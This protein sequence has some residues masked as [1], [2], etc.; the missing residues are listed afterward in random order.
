MNRH[1]VL[2]VHFIIYRFAL[3]LSCVERPARA[4][5]CVYVAFNRIYDT[6]YTFQQT[7]HQPLKLLHG[8]FLFFLLL[9]FI[10]VFL[11]SQ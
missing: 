3:S 2:F 1:F 10:C 4:R 7:D 8:L 6:R 5:V 9:L 11:S